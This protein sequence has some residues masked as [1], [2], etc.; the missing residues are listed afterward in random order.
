[1]SAYLQADCGQYKN[2]GSINSC[3]QCAMFEEAQIWPRD[4]LERF[5]VTGERPR[6]TSDPGR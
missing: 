1:M 3:T 6:W 2:I 5:L 4:I